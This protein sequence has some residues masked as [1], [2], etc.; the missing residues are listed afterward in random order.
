VSDKS[1]VPTLT[2]E[3]VASVR[4]RML[5]NSN[6]DLV[7]RYLDIMAAARLDERVKI[8]KW[9]REFAPDCDGADEYK[10]C[11]QHNR[12]LATK[13]ENNEHAAMIENG[14]HNK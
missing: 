13:I 1:P 12:E 14:E 11:S 4:A 5:G 9:L 7:K 2:P 8:A 3:E 6:S 10:S